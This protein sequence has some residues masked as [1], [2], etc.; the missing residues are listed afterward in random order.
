LD[1]MTVAEKLEAMEIIWNDL[2]QPP[3]DFSSPEWHKD[4][5]LKREQ[6]RKNGEEKF[7]D[8]ETHR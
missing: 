5:L 8:W 7:S 1:K 2:S 4:V 3:E 6:A